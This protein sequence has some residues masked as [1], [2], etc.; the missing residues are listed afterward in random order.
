M[1]NLFN[2]TIDDLLS[3]TELE[4]ISNDSLEE[5]GKEKKLLINLKKLFRKRVWIPIT[6][7]LSVLAIAL[8]I[9]TPIVS[10]S[11]R[12]NNYFME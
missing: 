11:K 2:V 9:D 4:R 5:L 10:S 7:V 1:A 8:I 12:R 6:S 3:K